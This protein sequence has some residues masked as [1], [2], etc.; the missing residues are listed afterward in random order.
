MIDEYRIDYSGRTY[1]LISFDGR[2]LSPIAAKLF[3]SLG[4]TDDSGN[5]MEIIRQVDQLERDFDN[6]KQAR[7]A[8]QSQIAILRE[9]IEAAD[10]QKLVYYL[11]E[12]APLLVMC[13]G[14]SW[15]ESLE[16]RILKSIP[17]SPEVRGQIGDLLKNMSKEMMVS[18]RA[19][20]EAIY[21]ILKQKRTADPLPESWRG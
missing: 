11:L 4:Y 6:E 20:D 9:E 8:A 12:L 3:C 16:V 21:Q 17:M 10:S 5:I 15:L 19:Y 13:G 2:L 14:Y 7:I 1:D 18:S